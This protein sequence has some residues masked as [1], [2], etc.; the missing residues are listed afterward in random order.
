MFWGWVPSEPIGALISESVGRCGRVASLR[1]GHVEE[2]Y[3]G[4]R[5]APSRNETPKRGR[6]SRQRDEG[7]NRMASIRDLKPFAGSNAL[8]I[9]AE[10]LA[11][12]A[13]SDSS[14]TLRDVAHRSTQGS[15]LGP[16]RKQV[17]IRLI[18]IYREPSTIGHES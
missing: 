13:D 15:A 2:I 11:K 12:F 1:S 5:R 16:P 18:T 7:G 4:W 10:V 14:W 17:D 9:D 8:E 3:V 6:W